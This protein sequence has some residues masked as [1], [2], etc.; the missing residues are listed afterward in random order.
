MAAE[1][2]PVQDCFSSARFRFVSAE[3]FYVGHG[4]HVAGD[5]RPPVEE[6]FQRRFYSSHVG[7]GK[8]S[9]FVEEIIRRGHDVACRV[10]ISAELN[11]FHCRPDNF[12]VR[13]ID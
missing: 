1:Q 7:R 4:C 12:D 13:R 5:A 10:Q 3:R 2:K 11:L 6:R 9:D 8:G